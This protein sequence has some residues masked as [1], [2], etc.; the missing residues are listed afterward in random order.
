MK[1]K[2]ISEGYFN[3]VRIKPGTVFEMKDEVAFAKK[4][5]AGN[6]M[7]PRWVVAVEGA[8]PAAAPA[9]IVKEEPGFFGGKKGKKKDDEVI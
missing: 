1:V 4:D 5:K 7:L 8:M 9:P 6:P 2:A 3:H